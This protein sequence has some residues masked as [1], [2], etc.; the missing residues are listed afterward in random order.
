VLSAGF[1]NE[2]K[3][4]KLKRLKIANL[5]NSKYSGGISDKINL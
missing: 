1:E 2:S 4:S 5:T 3:D